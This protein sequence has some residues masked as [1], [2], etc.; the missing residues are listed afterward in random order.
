MIPVL[1]VIK[2]QALPIFIWG[3]G[4]FGWIGDEIAEPHIHVWTRCL[5]F[6]TTGAK[7]KKENTQI[8]LWDLIS[9]LMLEE[10][11]LYCNFAAFGVFVF[12]FSQSVPKSLREC[13]TN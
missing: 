13:E 8:F 11:S 3:V 7:E 4:H 10:G 9:S 6:F 2:K 1:F 12:F 5:M